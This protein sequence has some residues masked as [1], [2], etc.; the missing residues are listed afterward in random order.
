MYMY[1]CIHA[2][3]QHGTKICKTSQQLPR[4]NL[5]PWWSVSSAFDFHFPMGILLEYDG[6]NVTLTSNVNVWKNHISESERVN[7][8]HSC[9]CTIEGGL[10]QWPYTLL[11]SWLHMFTRHLHQGSFDRPMGDEECCPANQGKNGQINVHCA[12]LYSI[13]FLCIATLLSRMYPVSFPCGLLHDISHRNL[14]NDDAQPHCVCCIQNNMS[15]S[16]RSANDSLPSFPQVPLA[17]TENMPLFFKSYA[18]PPSFS[19][20]HWNQVW[21]VV[22]VMLKH[23]YY[24]FHKLEME[25]YVQGADT[26]VNKTTRAASAS[27]SGYGDAALSQ[28]LILFLWFESRPY[29]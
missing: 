28:R 6:R 20:T 24:R 15:D 10:L 9:I 1:M 27:K 11:S 4:E 8:Q 23:L 19:I 3:P 25:Q 2:L 17:A 12:Y 26:C 5:F 22:M 18:P 16:F 21:F 14:S 13:F 29:R 7:N